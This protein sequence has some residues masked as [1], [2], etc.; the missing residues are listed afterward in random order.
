MEASSHVSAREIRDQLDRIL[1]SRAFRNSQRLQRFLKF[2]VEGVLDG[3]TDQLKE[4]VLGRVVF[5]R[6][7]EY[8]PRTDSI[9][10]VESQ[11]LRRKLREYYDTEGRADPVSI[12]FQ[13]GSYIP[14]FA[15][16]THTDTP[17]T[18]WRSD[19]PKARQL[20]PQT[21]A[22]LPLDN[23][24][25]DP[26]QEYFCDGITD[27]LIFAL[28]RIPGL[29]VISHTSM[30]ALKGAVHDAWD[31][32]ARLGAGTL[33]DGSVRKSDNQLKVFAEMIDATTGEVRWAETY[34]RTLDDVFTVQA[35]IAQAVA[36]VLQLTLA[37]SVSKRLICGAPTM[38]AYLLYLQGRYAWNRMSVDGYRTAAETF[39]RAISLYP[40]YALPYAGLANAYTHLALW[41]GARPRDAMPKAQQAATQA[42][43]LDSFLPHAHSALAVSTAF[44]E[45]QWEEGTRLAR[46][47][48]DLEPSYAFGHQV[49]G[50][51]LVA[52]GEMDEGNACFQR[53]IALD[54]LSVRA[55]RLLGWALHLQRRPS[56]A[57]KW[58][59]AALVLDREPLQTHYLLAHV[60]LSQ[61]RF[62]AALEQA[63]RCQTDPPDPL[64]LGVLG[65]SLA[66]LNHG[67]EAR[68]AIAKLSR[69]AKAGYIDPNAIAQVQ[70]AL[71]DKDAALE[72]VRR[73]LDE[74]VPFA[75]F[76]TFD[77]EFD[78]LRTDRRFS[79]LVSRVGI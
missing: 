18:P 15:Y 74:R 70:I 2:A 56:N 10:R 65:A 14:A 33:V 78:S 75:A 53:A 63:Q 41:G 42:L 13:P 61:G 7:S 24:S 20:N 27:E 35:E 72:S 50:C 59:Q 54:P 31:I 55:H 79:D 43:K 58:L 12:A 5:D 46:R 77:P 9:V 64:G 17:K 4:S 38:D 66:H 48:I 21:I 37:P 25:A 29:N 52:R 11:R 49:F 16:L 60:Y 76:L 8:D 22:V 73:S 6:G 69:L 3:T 32:A 36:R 44:Y 40:S 39:E 71:N 34:N 57:E 28:S 51:C 47:A 23:L 67:K 68:E 19:W 45:W 30:F 1:Q 26:E 62:A